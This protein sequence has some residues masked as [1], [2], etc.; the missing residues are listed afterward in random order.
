MTQFFVS[1]MFSPRFNVG[2]VRALRGNPSTSMER[3]LRG[4]LEVYL[5]QNSVDS[6][7][8]KQITKCMALD[9]DLGYSLIPCTSWE[10]ARKMAAMIQ[11]QMEDSGVDM[12]SH[13]PKGVDGNLPDMIVANPPFNDYPTNIE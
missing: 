8:S 12:V 4:A 2:R 6:D 9:D 11:K 1:T 5:T 10:A 13:G 7:I 3:T